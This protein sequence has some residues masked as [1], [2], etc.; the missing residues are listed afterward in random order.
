MALLFNHVYGVI[1]G[2]II[3]T[4]IHIAEG[5]RTK[6]TQR[7]IVIDVV[8]FNTIYLLAV[9]LNRIFPQ[10]NMVRSHQIFTAAVMIIVFK[11]VSAF[12]KV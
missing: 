2:L 7:E 4:F 10:L 11:G 6:E 3:F 8:V 9:L 12:L 1:F 5:I